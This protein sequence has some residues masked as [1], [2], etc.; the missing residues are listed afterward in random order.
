M[1]GLGR[2]PIRPAPAPTAATG[3]GP[4]PTAGISRAT[5]GSYYVRNTDPFVS[6]YLKE[7][8]KY[9]AWLPHGHADGFGLTV[10]RRRM[11]L[12]IRGDGSL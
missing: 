9:A 2:V 10:F 3:T 12:V 1:I 11:P 7:T 4:A 8:D 5:T 6:E